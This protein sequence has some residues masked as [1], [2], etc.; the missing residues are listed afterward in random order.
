MSLFDDAP[1]RLIEGDA[2]PAAMVALADPSPDRGRLADE[3]RHLAADPMGDA[4]ARL[5]EALLVRSY[6]GEA[7]LRA[8]VGAGTARFWAAYDEA[9]QALDAH[10]AGRA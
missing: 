6:G 9:R 4:L 1:H 5:L 8:A 10:R 3:G 2:Y 7:P